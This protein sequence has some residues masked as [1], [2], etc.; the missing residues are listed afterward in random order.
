MEALEAG[1]TI[2]VRTHKASHWKNRSIRGVRI[3]IS[4][5]GMGIPAA[6]IPRIFE[7]FLPPREKWDWVGS[8]GGKR[9]C[10]PFWWLDF[11][12]KQRASR[13]TRDLLFSLSSL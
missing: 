10:G 13:E 2:A 5:T 8:L 3:T 12:S 6:N 1:G 9:N 11:D 7:P 4:D